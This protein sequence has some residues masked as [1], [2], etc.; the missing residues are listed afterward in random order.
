MY[1]VGNRQALGDF[2][3]KCRARLSPIDVGLP[4]GLR[5]RTP[6]LRRE[7][8]AQLANIGT[9]WYIWLEQGR[10]V[11]PSPQVLESI[12]QALR[13]SPNERRHLFLLAGQPLPAY[14]PPLEEAVSLSLKRML[15]ALDPTPAY[16]MGRRW[17]YLAWNKT[18]D[19]IYSISKA[20]SSSPYGRN[21]LWRL[22]CTPELRKHPRFEQMAPGTIAE[23][24]AAYARYPGDR[25]FEEL[26]EDLQEASPEFRRLWPRHR[27]DAPGEPEVYKSMQ[28][29]RVGRLLFE[30]TTLQVPNDPDVKVMIYT[31]LRETR[32]KLQQLL[33]ESHSDP[34]MTS[35]LCLEIG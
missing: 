33:E 9:S 34:E 35:P 12:A 26:I 19:L 22:F 8:V 11:H 27:H 16:I 1:E 21:M 14:T 5:R 32:A 6:G 18:A 7:E 4:P 23:F 25:W 20:A 31:P 30:L 10:D 24:R 28:H 29:P 15:D 17:D 3:R 2:L 13:L